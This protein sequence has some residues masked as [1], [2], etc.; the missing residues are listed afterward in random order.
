MG[1]MGTEKDNNQLAAYHDEVRLRRVLAVIEHQVKNGSTVPEACEACSVSERSF[2]RWIGDG[3]LADYLADCQKSRS[4]AATALAAESVPDVMNYMISIA[5]GK[6]QARGANPI[7]AAQLIFRIAGL[8][9]G[10]SAGDKG[11]APNVLAFL[12]QMMTLNIVQSPNVHGQGEIV[13]AEVE[14]LPASG[15]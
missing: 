3:I 15:G 5:T 1:D 12:P 7:A 6:T 10:D 11:K 9:G 13:D 14:E 8:Q 4:G 2:Y